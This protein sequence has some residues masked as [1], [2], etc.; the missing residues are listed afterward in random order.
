MTQKRGVGAPINTVVHFFVINVMNSNGN[1]KYMIYI[2]NF[3]VYQLSR[4]YSFQ[5][6]TQQVY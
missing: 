1:E 4:C 6:F 5:C 3:N 2:V